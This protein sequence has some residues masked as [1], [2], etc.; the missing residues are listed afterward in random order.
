MNNEKKVILLVNERGPLTGAEIHAAAGGDFFDL[1]KVCMLSNTLQVRRTGRRFVR[2]DRRVEGLARLSPS[3]L[4]EFMTYSVVGLKQDP[5]ALESK[6][7]EI[8][9]NIRMISRRKKE[10]ALQAVSDILSGLGGKITEENMCVILAGDIVY[11]MA[12]DVPRPE[13]STGRLANGSDLD[14]VFVLD[15]KVSDSAVLELD[16]EIYRVKFRYL[17]NPALLEEIDYVVKKMSKVRQQAVFDS[18]K[19]VVACK[20]L[21]EGELLQGSSELF[22]EIREI[23]SRSGASKK[24]LQMR[25]QAEMFGNEAVNYFLNNASDSLPPEKTHLFYSTDEFEEFE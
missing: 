7:E 3:I 4:R 5:A 8:I 6:A 17:T 19:H 10:L 9:T 11:E 12:H 24:L 15:D 14:L 20:I 1:W 25:S 21:D 16:E 23:L 18:F 2:L 22:Q 13:R